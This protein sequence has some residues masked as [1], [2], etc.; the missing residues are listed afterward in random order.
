MLFVYL[1]MNGWMRSPLIFMTKKPDQGLNRCN[2][3][4]VNNYSNSVL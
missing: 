3:N 1:Q 4:W 2:G